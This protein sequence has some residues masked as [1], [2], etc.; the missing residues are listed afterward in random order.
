MT[1]QATSSLSQA[2]V[3]RLMAERS[4][5]VRAEVAGKLA[6]ELDN[7]THLS[8]AELAL[9]HD[10]V[11]TM[12]KDVEVSVRQA[13]SESLRNASRLPHDVALKLA[14]DIESVALPILTHSQVLT[15]DDLA[16]IVQKGAPSKQE[17]IAK[18]AVVSEKLSEALITAASE[19]AVA[20]LMGNTGARISEVSMNKAV[21]RFGD[22][23]AVKEKIVTRE[24]LPVAVTE[25]LVNLVSEN[26]KD[27]LVSHHELS[28]G[29][30]SDIMMGSRERTIIGL[31][32][33][34]SEQ[35]LEKLIAQ[36]HANKRLTAS[37]VLRAL[38]MGDIA[39][40]ET[41]MAVMAN[42]PLLNAR[43]LI[44]DG[45]KLGLKS[46]YMKT[47]LPMQFLSAVRI[48][49]DVVHETPMD[50]GARD[51]ERYRA[52]VIERVLT[53]AEILGPEDVDYLLEKLSA[54]TTVAA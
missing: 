3:A 1:E 20:T 54:I 47:G 28:P 26:L 45:G 39:F 23:T 44:H 22:S 50:G 11:R 27:Y 19:T 6:K 12:A 52:R 51:R 42:V 13:L 32:S 34:S 31:S 41:S 37:L 53:Q 29:V 4:P 24:T 49:I 8:E 2:D 30:A 10:I 18:R 16:N 17:A 40:F 14:N 38:C 21:D 9:A 35:D 46:L 43:I 7:N 5:L 33:A 15:D 36:M 48:A 25:R